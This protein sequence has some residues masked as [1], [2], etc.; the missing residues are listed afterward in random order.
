MGSH[1]P[2]SS[3]EKK[4]RKIALISAVAIA[5]FAITSI[6]SP[7]IAEA[8]RTI[9]AGYCPAGTCGIGGRMNVRDLKFCKSR[10]E[11]GGPAATGPKSRRRN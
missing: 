10:P 11:C 8:Q 3:W 7:E 9:R 4:M 2:M 5:L 6:A 1:D